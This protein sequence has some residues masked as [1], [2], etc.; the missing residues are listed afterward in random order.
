MKLLPLF[1]RWHRRIGLLVALPVL[2]WTLS[3]V[4]HPIMSR[5]NPQPANPA[6]PL[7]PLPEANWLAPGVALQKAGVEQLQALRLVTVAGQPYY[8]ASPAS[9]AQRIYI[10]AQNG[11][12]LD[13][14]EQQH[15]LEM[16]LHFTGR[17][18]ESVRA[19]RYVDQFDAEYLWINRLLPVWRI[20]FTSADHL[21]VYVETT[22]ARLASMVD[23]TKRITSTL[24]RM[25]HTWEI[26]PQHP[27]VTGLMTAMLIAAATMGLGGIVLYGILWR[28]NAFARRQRPAQRWHRSLGIG[29][30]FFACLFAFSGG[31]HL[32][33]TPTPVHMEQTSL[34]AWNAAALAATSA[35]DIW[36]QQANAVIVGCG[37]AV[38]RL[39]APRVGPMQEHQHHAGAATSVAFTLQP[40]QGFSEKSALLNTSAEQ[41]AR[42]ALDLANETPLASIEAITEFNGEYGFLKKRLP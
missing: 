21:S 32:L 4:L 20:D 15:A 29:V 9:N 24:F 40:V 3:G 25:L 19:I 37:D 26:L 14:G 12:V 42:Q 16:A 34:P 23:D 39:T 33:H 11:I 17:N 7:A 10:N 31:W 13:Q 36:S 18:A 27:L 28:R 6:P 22:P 38:C 30:S 35:T 2:L 5:L 8:Q 1:L 41:A